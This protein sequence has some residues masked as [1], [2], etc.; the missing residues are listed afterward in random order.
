M[1]TSGNPAI[2]GCAG[3]T[4]RFVFLICL[5]VPLLQTGCEDDVPPLPPS[6]Q[7]R[8]AEPPIDLR[9]MLQFRADR[10]VAIPN[11]ILVL[12]SD[13]TGLGVSLTTSRLA[14]DGTSVTF[15]ELVRD[16]GL[17]K[18]VG[19]EIMMRGGKIFVAAGNM[20]R[21]PT[22]VYKPREATMTITALT[23]QEATGTIKGVFYRF[24]VPQS[25]MTRPTEVSVDASFSARLIVK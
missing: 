4:P 12:Q 25:A 14:G 13:P 7:P 5:F 3:A 15:G 22:A 1:A 16:V 8:E 20:V 17:E 21:T 18:L 23:E 24:A 10:T 11:L 9:H 6:S 2:S 19:V